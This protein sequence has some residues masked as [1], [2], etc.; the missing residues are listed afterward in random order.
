[1]AVTTITRPSLAAGARKLGRTLIRHPSLLVGGTIVSFF[2]VIGVFAPVLAPYSYEQQDLLNNLLPPLS[3]GHLLGTDDFGRD[4]LT[5]LM[6]GT[7]NSLKVAVAITA[8]SLLVG[9]I[10]GALSGYFGG[11]LDYILSA[12]VD[13]AWGF[14]IVLIAVLAYGII[15]PGL[16]AVM[17]AVGA[18]N[19]AGCARIVRGEVLALREREFI[20]AARALGHGPFRIIARHIL[21]HT[22]PA[23]LVIGSFYMAVAILAEAALSFIGIGVQPPAASLGQMLVDGKQFMQ[24]SHWVATIPGLTILFLVVGFNLFGDGLRDVLDPRLKEF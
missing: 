13:F 1:M 11:V 2:V 6:Y 16:P 3:P 23:V 15:G 22:L 19:W 4:V 8:V 17:I 14:P 21:P 9:T 24:Q 12:A 10:V 7:A 5:R 20:E 18:V